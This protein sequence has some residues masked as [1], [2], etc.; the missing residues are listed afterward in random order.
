MNESR[1]ADVIV[2]GAGLAGLS[3]SVRLERSGLSVLLVESSDGVGGRVRSDRLDG[4]KLDR[5]F[6]VLLTAYPEAQRTLDYQALDLQ[7][8]I[9]GAMVRVGGSFHRV[10]D[11]RRRPADL[12]AALRAPVGSF[13]DKIRVGRLRARVERGSLEQIFE[14]PE[15]TTIEALRK[16]GFSAEMIERFMRPFLGGIFLERGLETSSRM[17]EFVFRMFAAGDA[18]LPARGMGAISDQ[19]VGCLTEGVLRTGVRV[20]AVERSGVVLSNGERLAARAVV[21]ATDG[22]SAASLLDGLDEPASRSVT[23]LYFAAERP[24]IEEPILVLNGEEDGPVN[25][26]CVPSQIARG[27]APAGTSL[28]SATVIG[29]PASGDE[30]LENDVRR[31]MAR[32]FGTQVRG[33]RHLRTY[34]IKHALPAQPPGNERARS[35]RFGPGLYVCGDHC[36]TASIEGSL[37]SARRAA[38]AVIEDLRA[39]EWSAARSGEQHC[40]RTILLNDQ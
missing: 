14:R 1:N 39:D 10:T 21:I 13:A 25:N 6:Q 36:E 31:Q 11:P 40:S 2:V 32:W 26:L 35:V 19:L 3:C 5:G 15:T 30:R 27:Y 7:T 8:F 9:P 37:I 34:R 29:N 20:V 22:V 38:E 4:F 33:W 17:F 12:A 16:A 24:P 18:A 28:I 23:C